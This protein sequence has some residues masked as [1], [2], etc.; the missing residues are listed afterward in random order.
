MSRIA[1]RDG[2]EIEEVRARF[3]RKKSEAR[4]QEENRNGQ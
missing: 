2:V 3:M 1:R 4:S